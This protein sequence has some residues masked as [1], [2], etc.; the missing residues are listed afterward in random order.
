[1]FPAPT[2]HAGS[3][4]VASMLALSLLACASPCLVP[5][6]ERGWDGRCERPDE[7]APD[8]D[9]A[10]D[11]ATAPADTGPGVTV[12]H[13][14]TVDCAHATWTILADASPDAGGA[15]LDVAGDLAGADR[16]ESHELV[17][18][19]QSHWQVSG[20][21]AVVDPSAQ[22][23]DVSTAFPCD[24]ADALT[25]R[26]QVW[27]TAHRPADCVAWGADPARFT[28]NDCRAW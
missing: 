11:D 12:I 14:R 1:V 19:P 8:T 18:V 5:G 7:P 15:I 22:E 28:S 23:P 17:V 9:A 6:E 26:L 25:W 2:G 21:L 16:V 3:G 4:Y 10:T 27:D 24:A 13:A 20:T